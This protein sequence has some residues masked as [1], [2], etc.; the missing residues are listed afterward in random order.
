MQ[1]FVIGCEKTYHVNFETSCGLHITLNLFSLNVQKQSTLH[2]YSTSQS[3]SVKG[4]Q[5]KSSMD[6]IRKMM[7]VCVLKSIST[8]VTNSVWLKRCIIFC[9]LPK[10]VSEMMI[11]SN[12]SEHLEFFTNICF[13][14]LGMVAMNSS[15]YV[16]DCSCHQYLYNT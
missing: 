14:Y 6:S 16:F 12:R 3:R 4:S 2:G 8:L 15:M 10:D 11:C 1:E 13:S 9:E 7:L 5:Q